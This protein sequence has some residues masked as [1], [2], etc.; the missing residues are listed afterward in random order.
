MSVSKYLRVLIVLG[1]V[2]SASLAV[3]T[4]GAAET[5]FGTS[6]IGS[7]ASVDV[8]GGTTNQRALISE[9][10]RTLDATHFEAVAVTSPPEEFATGA[11]WLEIR[12]RADDPVENV[13]AHWQ[14]LLLAGLVRDL[15]VPRALPDILGKTI[16]V[17]NS[18]GKQLETA[19]TV[20]DQPN[21]HNIADLTPAQAEQ[22][23]RASATRAGLEVAK[24]RSFETP[25][26]FVTEM[27]TMT[28]DAVTFSASRSIKLFNIIDA[29]NNAS[30]PAGEGAYI[31]VRDS[32][33]QFVTVSAYSVRTG[34]G[35]GYTNPAFRPASVS[36]GRMMVKP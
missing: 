18:L 13:F 34:E 28:N 9:I 4:F 32:L 27:L 36:L 14:A 15:S 35:V 22:R 12:V 10:L 29:L 1:A 25:G 17:V 26:G 3:A 16:T 11:D 23:V 5:P 33:G 6:R 21:Q 2:G 19:S 8:L 7:G 20:I 31:E 30:T 24:F